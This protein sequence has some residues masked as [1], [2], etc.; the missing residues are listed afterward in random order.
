VLEH[1]YY[2]PFCGGI[3]VHCVT[4]PHYIHHSSVDGHIGCFH[5]WAVRNNAAVNIPVQI[6]VWTYVFISR[7]YR[8]GQKQIYSCSYGK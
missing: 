8:D 6:F 1:V 5:F 3:M 2:I 4:I 7:I